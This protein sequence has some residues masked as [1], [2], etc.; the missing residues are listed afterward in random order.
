MIMFEPEKS[1]VLTI[2]SAG[3]IESHREKDF[4]PT[5]YLKK[6][7]FMVFYTVMKNV[8]SFPTFIFP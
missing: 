3:L 7:E 6:Y 1:R 2:M 4:H 8:V 5:V